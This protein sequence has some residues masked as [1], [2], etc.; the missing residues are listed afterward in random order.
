MGKSLDIRNESLLEWYSVDRI[1]Y[2]ADE[3]LATVATK[4]ATSD[5]G[6]EQR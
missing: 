6:G 3:D 2:Y 4:A 1:E 5:E